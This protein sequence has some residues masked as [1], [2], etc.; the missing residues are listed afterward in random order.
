MT[1]LFISKFELSYEIRLNHAKLSKVLMKPKFFDTSLS[2]F[3]QNELHQHLPWKQ[4][5]QQQQ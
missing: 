2:F 3:R 4:Q 5:Q 1:V